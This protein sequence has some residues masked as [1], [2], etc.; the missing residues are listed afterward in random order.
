M[1][2]ERATARTATGRDRT[3]FN[4]ETIMQ[5]MPAGDRSVA[6]VQVHG[7]WDERFTKVRDVLAA[8]LASGADVGASAAIFIDGEPVVDIWGG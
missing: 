2:V 7:L 3:D 8:Q 1:A 6:N 4:E 5:A